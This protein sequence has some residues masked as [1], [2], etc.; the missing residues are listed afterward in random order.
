MVLIGKSSASPSGRPP[1][2]LGTRSMDE[3]HD[4]WLAIAQ[5]H[6]VVFLALLWQAVPLGITPTARARPKRSAEG[7]CPLPGSARLRSKA[8]LGEGA[9]F[10]ALTV[11]EVAAVQLWRRKG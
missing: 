2:T 8:L 3:R 5:R 10:Q 7:L 11:C 9:S 6:R 4:G 1:A